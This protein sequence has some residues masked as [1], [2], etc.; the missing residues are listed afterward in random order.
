MKSPKINSHKLSYHSCEAYF[1]QYPKQDAFE[2]RRN[3]ML[4]KHKK[5]WTNDDKTVIHGHWYSI[6]LYSTDIIIYLPNG[7]IRIRYG[8][9]KN[10]TQLTKTRINE[11]IP[12]G[13]LVCQ[14]QSIKLPHPDNEKKWWLCK[15]WLVNKFN[16]RVDKP[17]Q[18]E[19]E[20]LREFYS[21][22]SFELDI[23]ANEIFQSK[24]SNFKT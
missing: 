8:S 18:K 22:F 5:H 15:T 14:D 13:F 4:I 9:N 12:E 6:R 21:P 3:L 20:A 2:L 10:K 17:I 23:T 19:P 24:L 16:I 11:C 7:N 1:K